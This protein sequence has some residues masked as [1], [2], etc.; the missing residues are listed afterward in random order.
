MDHMLKATATGADLLIEYTDAR[1]KKA[2]T[3]RVRLSSESVAS[4][5]VE[6][7]DM[8][9]SGLPG[10]AAPSEISLSTAVALFPF[11]PTGPD[12]IA[13]V[14][15]NHYTV[16][17]RCGGWLY[18]FSPS[19]P[20]VKAFFPFAYCDLKPAGILVG[21]CM[22]AEDWKELETT[23]AVNMKRGE[24]V[25]KEGDATQAG[26]TVFSVFFLLLLHFSSFAG[27]IFFVQSGSLVVVKELSDG[28]KSNVAS[29]GAGEVVGGFSPYQC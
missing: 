15:G 24:Y 11:S 12:Q 6:V 8:M 27:H 14:P 25:L 18:G 22:T 28:K 5:C 19:N 1:K 17:D 4:S 3:V 7:I 26:L 23:D 9:H 16:L 10:A 2:R 21:G 13:L 20:D 29:L